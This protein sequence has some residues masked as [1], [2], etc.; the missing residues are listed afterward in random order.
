MRSA[1]R[2]QKSETLEKGVASMLSPLE[3]EVCIALWKYC[4]GF[5]RMR[6]RQI[7]AKL[8]GKKVALTSVAVILDR[9]YKQGLVDRES[10]TGRGGVFYLYYPKATRKEV[11]HTLIDSAVNNLIK[12]FGPSAVTYFNERFSK[13]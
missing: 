6:V 9:L 11:E 3:T 1:E 8:K 12:S 5:R 7:H 13:S 2:V 4:S 10:G